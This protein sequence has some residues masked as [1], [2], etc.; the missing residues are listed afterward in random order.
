MQ[1]IHS[2]QEM[3]EQARRWRNERRSVALV[4]TM[5]FL[6]EGHLS[7]ARLAREE[8][9]V[10]VMSIFVNPAQFGPHEDFASYPRDWERDLRLAENCGVDCLFAPCAAEMYPE[11]YGT[12]VEVG[13]LGKYLCGA[14][15]PGHFRG[16]ATVVCKLFNIVQPKIAVFGQKDGQQAAILQ[17]MTEDL[18]LPVII[19]KAPIV[20]E[21]D[22]LA[23]S[24]RN[25]RL[26]AEERRQAAC[27]FQALLLGKRLIEAGERDA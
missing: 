23:M 12:F 13:E 10:V 16:V 18:N 1:I 9:G 14:S 3:I 7:L 6:H 5:G 26:S 24:S 17:K 21:A 11:G 22:G 8:A 20:R 25:I 2:V 19:R 27:L 4:P 15:R